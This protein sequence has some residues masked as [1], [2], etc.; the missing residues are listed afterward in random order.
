MT[1]PIRIGLLGCGTIA[2]EHHVPSLGRIAGAEVVA[3]A[4]PD[5]DA[6]ARFARLTDATLYEQPEEVLAARRR[7]RGGDRD[8]AGH[9]CRAGHRSRS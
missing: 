9:A 7:R 3:A 5:P 4:D 6:R 8:A 1:R 2:R